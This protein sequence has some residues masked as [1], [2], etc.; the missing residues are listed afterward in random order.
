M[1]NLGKQMIIR[2]SIYFAL[3]LVAMMA[4]GGCSTS[5]SFRVPEN[6]AKIQDNKQDIDKSFNGDEDLLKKLRPKDS[7]KF[8][9]SD[10][11]VFRKSSMKLEDANDDI[12]WRETLIT[13]LSKQGYT[14]VSKGNSSTKNTKGV[15]VKMAKQS[16]GLDLTYIVHFF[17]N[18]NFIYTLEA[19]GPV[20]DVQKYEDQIVKTLNSW[21][22]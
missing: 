11:I 3:A 22:I 16:Q 18:K 15:F 2:D 13:K 10:G 5:Q 6:F 20:K 17:V 9:S 12:F 1:I 8:V 21:T 7:S 19:G 4:L 14:V